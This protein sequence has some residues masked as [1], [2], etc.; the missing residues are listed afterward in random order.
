MDR[1][2]ENAI[3]NAESRRENVR[4]EGARPVETKCTLRGRRCRRREGGV[5][6]RRKRKRKTRRR[7]RR[8]PPERFRRFRVASV[9]SNGIPI[10]L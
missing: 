10:S 8:R 6:G 5:I 4:H 1:V 7:R 3:S 2:S 9:R